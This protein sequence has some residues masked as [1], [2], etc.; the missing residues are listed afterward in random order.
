MASAP[1]VLV[2][3]VKACLERG[4]PRADIAQSLESGGWSAR[5]A[6]AALDAFVDTPLPVPVPKKRVSSSPRDAFLHLLGMAM[7]YTAAC[8]TGTILFQFIDRWLPAP[9]DAPFGL[10][11]S[12]LRTAAA[13]LI[14]SLPIVGLVHRTT[15][16]DASRDPALRLTPVYRT[17]AYLTLLITSLVMAGDLIATIISFLSGELTARFLLKALVILLLA[18]GI[19]LWFSSDVQ[20]EEAVGGSPGKA[21]FP[22]PPPWRA[23]LHRIGATAALV[24]MLAALFVAG[25]PFR[26]R[27]L[28]LD[29]RRV[30]DLRSIQQNIE[31]YFEREAALP[32]SIESLAKNPA[33]FLHDTADPVTGRPYRYERIDADTYTLTAAFD[34]PSPP[35]Q[36]Q[37]TWNRDGFF[38]HAAGEQTFRLSAPKKPPP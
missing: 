24:S 13:A 16:R 37:P 17:L 38:R 28:R 6:K 8:A 29:T 20:R 36:D 22:P 30:D 9:G 21:S 5:E 10:S 18:G 11:S 26:Q 33:T 31:T 19:Y 4:L 32:D 12:I 7:L 14:V 15:G 25:S 35:E 27:L 2:A 3:V 23:W 1:D 34:L